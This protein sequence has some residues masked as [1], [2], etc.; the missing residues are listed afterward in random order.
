MPVFDRDSLRLS[1]EDVSF[2]YPDAQKPVLEHISFTLEP[3]ERLAIVG[4]NGSGKTTLIKL[5]CRLYDPTAGCITLGGID[6]R[7]IPHDRYTELFGTVLQD[8]CLFAYSAA[9]NIVF[10]A[11]PDEARLRDSI[12]K[13]G[14]A[15]KIGSL[16]AG[17]NT[18]VGK[19]LDG[20]GIE[21]SGGEGQKLAL[22]RAVYKN[23]AILIL[24]EP[25][26]ALDPM[27][28][29][30]LFT[31]LADM[32]EGRSALFISHRLS[33]T[34]FCNRI[35]VLAEGRIAEAGSHD[36]LMAAGG[37]YAELF[38]T[39]A[40]YYTEEGITECGKK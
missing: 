28:E 6:I 34:R 40:G 35:M 30:A 11:V 27:A 9:E 23:A 4:L 26:S 13:S 39:Q 14:L 16:P 19:T 3:G 7:K 32:A 29:L 21:F 1:F 22:A 17:M 10:D 38:A 33:S 37:L 36:T 15:E 5:L 20:N 24:D 12:E 25:T 31:R 8:F 18:P 2:T